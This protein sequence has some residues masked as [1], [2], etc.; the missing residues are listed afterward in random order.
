MPR[1][2]SKKSK[3]N[4]KPR[5]VERKNSSIK[6]WNTAADIELDDEDQF[7]A[8]RDKILLEGE[9]PHD[10]EDGDEDEVFGLQGLS[11]SEDSELDDIEE[12]IG[13][14]E[15]ALIQKKSKTS[16]VK[17]RTKGK[18]D[19]S[20]SPEHD[21][22]EDEETWGASKA[23]YYSSNAI[24]LESDDEE[25]NELE[26]Q[27]ALRLQAKARDAMSD[28]D[29]GL[30]GGIEDD[31]G[32]ADVEEVLTGPS[33]ISKPTLPTDKSSLLRYL[34][35]E[36]PEALALAHDWDDT[37]RS[38]MLTQARIAASQ[39]ID[40]DIVEAGLLHLYYQ[41][42]LTYAT[43]LA[44]YLHLRASEK[45]ASRPEL[46]RKHPVL[47]RLLTLKQSLNTLDN[48]GVGGTDGKQD[49][50]SS[51]SDAEIEDIADEEMP[52]LWSL[53]RKEGLDKDELEELL[54]DATTEIKSKSKAL[55]PS[56]AKPP[57]KKRKTSNSNQQPT[58]PVFDLVEPTFPSSASSTKKTHS[59]TVSD[60]ANDA[61][62]EAVSLQH[63]DAEDKQARKKTLRFHV[64]RIES[65]SARRQNARVNAAGGDD[66]IPYRERRKER[67]A[68]L[69]KE[70]LRKIGTLGKGGDDLDDVEPELVNGESKAGNKKRRREAELDADADDAGGDGP[71]GYYELVKQRV[72]EKKMKKKA[73]YEEAQLSAQS[74]F[75]P[76]DANGPR[77]ITRAILKNKG[78][79]P[80]RSKSVRNPRVKKRQKFEKAKKR[81]SS[82]KAVY[83]G[84]I[85]DVSK[86]SGETSGIS[87]VVKSVR[88]G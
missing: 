68:R 31:V 49:N 35:I 67:E 76:E 69:E 1:R 63:A 19:A 79:T 62:G 85:G 52:D 4:A 36:N 13:T 78:L 18:K 77:S 5:P 65:A 15:E 32:E 57:K 56:S 2:P 30:A 24:Q 38:M 3:A 70:Q 58:I 28:D 20:P 21:S 71:D 43:T 59:R 12:D 66:D 6:R 61:F 48:L 80:H 46:L 23:A 45:Y 72:A 8:S 82:Q 33:Q 83:K 41:A 10:D 88:L 27:E 44:F 86:Y 25:A 16:K 11:S 47:K 17:S 73:D 42:L 14:R 87:K 84:G 7:H 60:G 9:G 39:E 37:V 81:V 75:D 34:Q 40:S 74:S 54:M 29:F 55:P 26:E 53:I 64:S 51:N 22:E 50:E